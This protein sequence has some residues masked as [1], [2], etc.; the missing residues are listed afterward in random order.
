MSSSSSSS[1]SS[2]TKSNNSTRISSTVDLKTDENLEYRPDDSVEIDTP[3]SIPNESF[4][5]MPGIS[6]EQQHTPKSY[7]GAMKY[8]YMRTKI[9]RQKKKEDDRGMMDRGKLYHTNE[10]KYDKVE[11][12]N[13]INS[14]DSFEEEDFGVDWWEE[15]QSG[16]GEGKIFECMPQHEISDLVGW[17]HVGESVQPGFIP[18]NITCLNIPTPT[19]QPSFLCFLEKCARKKINQTRIYLR[20]K[21]RGASIDDGVR[22]IKIA[23]ESSFSD[24]SQNSSTD[25]STCSKKSIRWVPSKKN[26]ISDFQTLAKNE[27]KSVNCLRHTFDETALVALGVLVQEVMTAVFFPLARKHVARCR[28][29][30][31][32]RTISEREERCM[33][34]KQK[35]AKR[36]KLEVIDIFKNSRVEMNRE[37]DELP[38]IQWALPPSEAI[39]ALTQENYN[40]PVN[41][42][43]ENSISPN[44]YANV[45]QYHKQ[46]YQYV[47]QNLK[48]NDSSQKNPCGPDKTKLMAN[49]PSRQKSTTM[50]KRDQNLNVEKKMEAEDNNNSSIELWCKVHEFNP[51]FVKNN[52]DIFKLFLNPS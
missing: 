49:I 38:L 31:E 20:E 48:K 35:S 14:D 34:I 51:S 41:T 15:G 40:Q 4:F 19:P 46:C 30:D 32:E 9:K 11:K 1:L 26:Q 17:A 52:M 50:K 2:T 3:I 16:L 10:I 13:F 29:L 23:D 25:G 24:S 36:R 5:I 8:S 37:K 7:Q 39:T 45:H 27:L 22:T 12:E 44:S 42:I 47:D 43:E 33:Y 6:R 18:T 21:I 28:I